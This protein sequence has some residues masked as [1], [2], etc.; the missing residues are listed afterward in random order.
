MEKDRIQ[1]SF[2]G[3]D[4]TDALKQY[5]LEKLFK[6]ENLLEEVTGIEAYLKQQKNSKGIQSD[7]RIDVD[8]HL[9]KADVRV[10]EI[11]SDMYANIDKATDVIFRKLKRYHDQ[12][13][14]WEGSE[15]WKVLEAETELSQFVEEDIDDYS[16]Y[17]PK[18]AKRKIVEDMSPLEE[19]EAIER[20]ELMG[21]DQYLFRSKKTNKISMIY[22]RKDGNY[23]LVEP[24][25]SME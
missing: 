19:G 16:D 22:K 6:K 10:E 8:I 15:S 9:P 11:G 1:V 21:Y 12:K 20:M 5:F 7:F 2:I 17:V 13:A 4:P 23:G 25:S 3:M 24:A 18:I 14:H